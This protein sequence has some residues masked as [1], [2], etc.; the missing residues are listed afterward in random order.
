MDDVN[1]IV[2]SSVR[3]ENSMAA[4]LTLYRHLVNRRGIRLYV[5]PAEHHELAG[6]SVSSKIVPR[7]MRT[8][9]RYWANDMDYLMHTTLPLEKRLPA[10]PTSARTVVLTLAYRSGCWVAQRYAKRHGLPLAVRF[11]DWWPDIALV[12]APVRKHLERRFLELHRSA[13]LSL[14]ISEGM[15]KALGPHRNARVILPIPDAKPIKPSKCKDS[16]GEFRVG[17]SGNMF[18]YSDMLADLAQLALKQRDVRIEFRGR[19]RWPQALIHEMKHRHLLHDFEPGPGFDDWLGSFDAYLVVMFFDA[20]QRRRTETCFA[21]KLVDYS[22]A[23]RPVVIWAPE[24]SAVVQWTKKSKAA[25]CV[26]DPDARAL[27]AALADLKRDR[28]L[29]LELGARIRRAYEA[30]FSPVGLQQQFME[31]LNSVI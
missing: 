22:R 1:V 23:G 9:A 19:P 7:L 29:Q 11:D 16:A 27:L 30:E 2:V 12:H 26:T 3:P 18:D 20:A 31:A 25:L 4:A 24:S 10:P 13:D 14:C 17:Y 8:S 21:T 28:A 6:G 15:L 5:F